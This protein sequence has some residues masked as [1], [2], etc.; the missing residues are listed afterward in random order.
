MVGMLATV[1][2]YGLL[3]VGCAFAIPIWASWCRRAPPRSA[4][5]QFLDERKILLLNA[6]LIVGLIAMIGPNRAWPFVAASAVV[7]AVVARVSAGRRLHSFL[8]LFS[9]LLIASFLPWWLGGGKRLSLPL[10]MSMA[11]P[12]LTGGVFWMLTRDAA[13]LHVQRGVSRLAWRW[14]AYAAFF[15]AVCVVVLSTGVSQTMQTATQWHHWGAYIGPAQLIAA[16]A[17]PLRDFPLQ[18]GFGPSVI[19]AL[20]G[21]SESWLAMYWTAGLT[22]IAFTCLVAYLA[23]RL[24][25]FRH[26]AAIA[27]VLVSCLFACLAWTAYPPQLLPALATPSTTGLRFLP[28]LLM[29]TWIVERILRRRPLGRSV[30]WGHL[31]WLL[32]I[33]WSPEAG[34]HATAVWAPYVFW[35]RVRDADGAGAVARALGATAEL[36]LALGGGLV[37][38]ACGYRAVWAEWPLLHE[39]VAYMLYPPGPLPINPRGTI[40]FAVGCVAVWLIAWFAVRHVREDEDATARQAGWVVALFFLATLSYFLGRSHDN[41]ILNLLPYLLLL[42]AATR[43]MTTLTPIR[44]VAAGLM[45]AIV[46]WTPTFGLDVYAA[47]WHAGS[48]IAFAPRTLTQSFDRI[49]EQSLARVRPVF[50]GSKSSPEDAVIALKS[51][52]A[53]F[54]EPVEVYDQA[55]LLDSSEQLPPWSGLHGPANFYYFPSDLRR[56]YLERVAQR[57]RRPGWVLYDRNF[58]VAAHL[59]DYDAVYARDRELDFGTYRAIRYVPKS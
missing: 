59:S 18:Y 33:G 1:S 56:T 42:L 41:N 28:G 40:V 52:R 24:G 55:F 11:V 23:I 27:A 6:A 36:G 3:G 4:G 16:G 50:A 12:A 14:A 51:I 46:G 9:A 38:L 32:C 21:Q 45:A 57:F 39:Y 54:R 49:S 47:A 37:A 10:M 44:A 30:I 2:L 13:A 17:L 31:L 48:V 8:A 15:I 26:P 53:T 43:A 20:A 34:F 7:A 19:L 29:L 58:D 22:T 5:G 25:Q 35:T